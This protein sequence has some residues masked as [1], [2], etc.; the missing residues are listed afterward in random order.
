L[1]SEADFHEKPF[2]N[3]D[4]LVAELENSLKLWNFQTLPL[5]SVDV[6]FKPTR[7][8]WSQEAHF[9]P[10]C[11]STKQKKI[12]LTTESKL[13]TS[14]RSCLTKSSASSTLGIC[15]NR[16]WGRCLLEYLQPPINICW[17]S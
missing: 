2:N 17:N 13:K 12:K 15:R 9:F 6:S 3:S 7:A 11:L 16:R 10:R 8:F 4:Q 1:S 14:S 5:T